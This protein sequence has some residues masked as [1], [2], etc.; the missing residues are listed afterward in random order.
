MAAPNYNVARPDQYGK[1]L[2]PGVTQVDPFD[3]QGYG[4]AFNPTTGFDPNI[5]P[6]DF[7]KMPGKSNPY[8][9]GSIFYNQYQKTGMTNEEFMKR[10]QDQISGRGIDY[11]A[12]APTADQVLKNN[13]DKMAQ[14]FRKNLPGYE[15][16]MFKDFQNQ[17]HQRLAQNLSQIKR[18]SASRGLMNSGIGVGNEARAEAE[19]GAQLGKVR[20]DINTQSE[21]M[22]KSLEADAIN[23]G[24]MQQ[25]M[26][27]DI[28][29]SIYNQ[30]LKNLAQRRAGIAGLGQGVGA[31]AGV[32]LAGDKGK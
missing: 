25:K 30:A 5:D 24:I 23:N 28:N 16:G 3:P 26:Q 2:S 7:N 22:A 17:E 29:D 1:I 12:P 32:A 20:S 21:A 14:D 9:Q 11:N 10:V 19:S 8:A 18:D 31:I 27:S 6:V 13:K 15:Q 4:K